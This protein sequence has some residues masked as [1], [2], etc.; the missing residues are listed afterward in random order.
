MKY[1]D[2]L[3]G[4]GFNLLRLK[5]HFSGLD[6]LIDLFRREGLSLPQKSTVS[7]T[8]LSQWAFKLEAAGKLRVFAL[9][10][11]I[12]QTVLRPLHDFMFEILKNL[13]N[14]GTFD[15]DACVIRSAE[16][17]Q[18]YGIA[19]S[20]DLSAATDRL[21]VLLTSGIIESLTGVKGIGEA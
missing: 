7:G 13:P 2:A 20:F 10:D 6:D 15:Q 5:S 4:A 18:K 1:L 16:K 19:F 21:P 9:L 3:K 14:D 8:G 17:F 12:S 11:S